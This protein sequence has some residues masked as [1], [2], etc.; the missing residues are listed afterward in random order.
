MKKIELCN[1]DGTEIKF[2]KSPS[3]M[4]SKTELSKGFYFELNIIKEGNVAIEI[5][6]ENSVVFYDGL[7]GEIILTD[8]N[9][10]VPAKPFKN[11][12][13]IGCT[14]WP[15]SL[16]RIGEC[17]SSIQFTINGKATSLGN[18]SLQGECITPAVYAEERNA[19]LD[20]NLGDKKFQFNEGNNQIS[21]LNNVK[22]LYYHTSFLLNGKYTF[23]ITIRRP[24]S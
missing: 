4:P 15:F 14:I 8:R 6:S 12:D 11:G 24:R 20:L 1:Q 5:K 10:V 22:I 3:N 23:R 9:I 2:K 21:I 18:H 13:I 16:H 19:L 7:H 17:Y